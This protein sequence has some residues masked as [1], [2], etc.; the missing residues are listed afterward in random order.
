MHSDQGFD[1]RMRYGR[2]NALEMGS[3]V[4]MRKGTGGAPKMPSDLHADSACAIHCA[5]CVARPS[6]SARTHSPLG[7]RALCACAMRKGES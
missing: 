1:L 5:I 2:L 7:V 3:R 6:H 4:L